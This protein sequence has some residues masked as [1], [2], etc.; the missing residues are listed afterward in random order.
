MDE[1]IEGILNDYS[2]R[3]REAEDKDKDK[4]QYQAVPLD[5]LTS[6]NGFFTDEEMRTFAQRMMK[7]LGTT[8]WER[9]AMDF[10]RYYSSTGDEG[11]NKGY[12]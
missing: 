4:V 10:Y 9:V 5:Q 8:D 3:V 12:F 1:V 7:L 11:S 6:P 2:R